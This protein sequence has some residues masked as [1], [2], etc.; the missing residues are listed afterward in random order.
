MFNAT[1]KKKTPLTSIK[2]LNPSTLPTNPI[3]SKTL[4]IIKLVNVNV[5]KKGKEKIK[6]K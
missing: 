3:T 6:N 1:C 4:K 5:F 2:E